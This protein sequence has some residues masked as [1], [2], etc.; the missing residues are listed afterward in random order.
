MT[1]LHNNTTEH[2]LHCNTSHHVE[3]LWSLD[4]D[5]IEARLIGHRL[6]GDNSETIVRQ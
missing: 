5:E 6:A 1:Q 2:S 3:Q 4:R